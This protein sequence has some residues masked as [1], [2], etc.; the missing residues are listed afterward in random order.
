MTLSHYPPDTKIVHC[1]L[2]LTVAK[3]TKTDVAGTLEKPCSGNLLNAKHPV[4]SRPKRDWT[5]LLVRSSITH[6]LSTKPAL[7][8]F[9]CL[10]VGREVFPAGLFINYEVYSAIDFFLL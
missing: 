10:P 4:S 9:A 1:H 5:S 6:S 2:Y 3:Q 7:Q 8:G